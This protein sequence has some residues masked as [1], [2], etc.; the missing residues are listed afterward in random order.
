MRLTIQVVKAFKCKDFITYFR[1]FRTSPYLFSC[2]MLNTLT[3]MRI[4]A[5]EQF[6]YSFKTVKEGKL[7][8]EVELKFITEELCFDTETDAEKFVTTLGYSV[9]NGLL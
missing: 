8:K 2:A 3:I 5:I 7:A 1:I 9:E 4:E 6:E